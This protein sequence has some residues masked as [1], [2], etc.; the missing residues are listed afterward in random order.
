MRSNVIMAG[1]DGRVPQNA[2]QY[3]PGEIA[4]RH[5]ENSE[6]TEW[7]QTERMYYRRCSICGRT[8]FEIEENG[9]DQPNCRK[10]G[11]VSFTEAKRKR[12]ERPTAT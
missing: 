6:L 7:Q 11:T 5:L 12:E 1:K 10:N 8:G 3:V 9:C 4:E 2:W